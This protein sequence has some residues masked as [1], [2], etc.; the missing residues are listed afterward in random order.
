M[1]LISEKDQWKTNLLEKL[2]HANTCSIKTCVWNCLLWILLN[3]CT[4]KQS[5][6]NLCSCFLYRQFI[7]VHCAMRFPFFMRC[8]SSCGDVSRC[9]RRASRLRSARRWR[10]SERGWMTDCLI[11][12]RQRW[13]RR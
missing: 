12:W 6:K 13:K 11:T 8:I 3:R 4:W 10:V 7:F 1:D 5:A 2:S 9:W